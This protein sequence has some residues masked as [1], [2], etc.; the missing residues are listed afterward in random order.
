M[1][2]DAAPD[3]AIAQN[4]PVRARFHALG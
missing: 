3:L 1:P 4:V 2:L